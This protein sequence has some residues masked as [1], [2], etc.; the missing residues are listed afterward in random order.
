METADAI[1]LKKEKQI[2]TFDSNSRNK[3]KQKYIEKKGNAD[4]QEQYKS[5]TFK[6]V[7]TGETECIQEQYKNHTFKRVKKGRNRDAPEIEA[8]EMSF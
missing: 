6:R 5:H 1:E 7:K 4:F 8:K 3:R 2:A